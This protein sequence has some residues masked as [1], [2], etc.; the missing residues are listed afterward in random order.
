MSKSLKYLFVILLVSFVIGTSWH[1]D[2]FM[3][4][5]SVVISILDPTL[6]ALLNYNLNIGLVVITALLSLVLTFF[7]KYMTDQEALREIKKEQKLLQE[8]MKEFKEHPE[9][10]VELQKKSLQAIPQM[11]EIVLRPVIFT[12]IPFILLFRWFGDYFEAIGDFKLLFFF[13]GWILPYLILSI[14]FSS[15]FRK[16]FNVA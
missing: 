6:G 5:R 10:V 4:I 16:V 9:K 7:Q 15:I 1:S 11:Y 13:S 8:Q 14:I 3:P 12:A 2:A